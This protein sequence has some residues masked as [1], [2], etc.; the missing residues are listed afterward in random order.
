MKV[1]PISWILSHVWWHL[2]YLEFIKNEID[3]QICYHACVRQAL[4]HRV[5]VCVYACKNARINTGK[6]LTQIAE[7]HF[8]F[9]VRSTNLTYAF[10]FLASHF[11]H[12]SVDSIPLKTFVEAMAVTTAIMSPAHFVLYTYIRRYIAN[13][14]SHRTI[15]ATEQ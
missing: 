15:M 6:F 11:V 4:Q 1:R 8:V 5:C 3:R 9:L 13:V 7:S 12:V 14:Y 2:V 10:I